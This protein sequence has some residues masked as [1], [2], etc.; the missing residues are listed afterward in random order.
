MTRGAVAVALGT[1]VALAGAARAEDV[2][3]RAVRF[4]EVPPDVT[5]LVAMPDLA[6]PELLDEIGSGIPVTILTRAI[7]HERGGKQ[8][9]VAFTSATARVVYDLWQERY[10][11]KLVD[12][13]GTRTHEVASR[14][15]A[16]RLATTL[17]RVP[18][19]PIGRLVV[20][21]HYVAAFVV[22]VNPISEELLAEVRR[23]LARSTGAGERVD[24]AFFSSV[25]SIFVNPRLDAAERTLRFRSGAFYR[26]RP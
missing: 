9:P 7:V 8:A 1:L 25:V 10:V 26:A 5:C 24:A 17:D 21:R 14:D 12:R 2:A 18:L 23:W 20:G 13:R 4:P 3:V 16:V 15:E 11:V 6:T 22:E 19:A